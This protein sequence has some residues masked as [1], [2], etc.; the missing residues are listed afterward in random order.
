MVVAALALAALLGAIALG[1]DIAVL[2]FNWAQL[3][4]GV[5]SAALAGAR[6]LPANPAKASQVAI[7]HA[8]DAGI[9]RSELNSPVISQDGL[10]ITV[11]ANR[12]APYLFLQLI[13]LE[14]GKVAASATAEVSYSTGGGS[15]G[16]HTIGKPADG[17]SAVRPTGTA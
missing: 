7:S 13:G 9:A 4:N 1:S 15:G 6:Y 3:Q 8:E 12:S 5:E 11:S 2:Y 10:T 16:H 17:V 14:R